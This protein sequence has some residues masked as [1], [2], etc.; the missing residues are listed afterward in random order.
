MLSHIYIVK[1]KGGLIK[2]GRSACP[3]RRITE[4]AKATGTKVVK[5]HIFPLCLNAVKI[6]RC[7]HKH[8]AEYRQQGEWF[9]ISFDTAVKEAKK[10]EFQTEEPSKAIIFEFESNQLRTMVDE[11]GEPWFCLKDACDILKIGNPSQLLKR[12]NKSGVISNEVAF[13]RSVA[14]L[15][16]INEPNFYRVIFGSRKKEAVIFQDWVFEKVLPSIR[17]TGQY[18]IPTNQQLKGKVEQKTFE[19]FINDCFIPDSTNKERARDIY[20]VYQGWCLYNK[21]EARTIQWVGMQL[22]KVILKVNVH[23]ME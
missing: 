11:N 13:E 9:D 5:Q 10:Q 6:E 23:R 18:S 4:I 8:F 15:N 12:L 2:I 3:K 21:C 14:R 20:L 1:A 16:F 7:L 22:R 19:N 17:K